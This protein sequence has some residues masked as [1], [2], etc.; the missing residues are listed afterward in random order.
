MILTDSEIIREIEE[1]GIVIQP[2]NSTCLGSNSYDLHLGDTL[3][4]YKSAMPAKQVV[5]DSKENNETLEL[6]IPVEGKV[7]Y[8]GTLYL[9]VT[10][11]YTETGLFVPNIDG[12][13]SIGRLGIQVHI[14]AGRGDIG[15]KGHWTLEITVVHPVRVYAGMKIAQ[16]TYMEP[17]GFCINPYSSK[18]DAKYQNQG[19]KPVASQNFE[20]FDKPVITLTNEQ[21]RDRFMDSGVPGVVE[22]ELV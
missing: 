7:L 10:Q 17:K 3:L 6:K 20:N 16:L 13:S 18:K 5:L 4:I 12:K 2:F 14:T 22:D 15:F 1:G 21:H 9:G 8:P 19:P 11:E